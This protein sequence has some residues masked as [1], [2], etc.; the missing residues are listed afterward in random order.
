MSTEVAKPQVF[1]RTSEKVSGF[2]TALLWYT[3]TLILFFI[4]F[5]FLDL[6]FLFFF[7]FIL[8]YFDNEKAHDCGHMTYHMM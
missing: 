3:W 7:A 4:L 8:F 2:I 5:I 6:I 1:D